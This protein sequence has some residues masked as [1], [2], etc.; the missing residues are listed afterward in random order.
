MIGALFVCLHWLE[1]P[2]YDSYPECDHWR[3][4]AHT[5]TH[6]NMVI[7]MKTSIALASDD[8]IL[9]INT[10]VMHIFIT[11]TAA[12]LKSDKMRPLAPAAVGLALLDAYIVCGDEKTNLSLF[13]PPNARRCCCWCRV[14]FAGMSLGWGCKATGSRQLSGSGKYLPRNPVFFPWVLSSS[15]NR[16]SQNQNKA[17]T[18][19]LKVCLVQRG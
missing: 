18:M 8:C 14:C 5:H 6:K 7:Q 15:K 10:H 9:S 2:A 3:L 12:I 17:K 1:C 13:F 19:H 16:V 11:Q 4:H